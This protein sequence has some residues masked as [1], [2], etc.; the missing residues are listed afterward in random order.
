MQRKVFVSFRFNDGHLYK[1]KLCEVLSKS[2]NLIDCSEDKDRSKLSEPVIRDYLY[3]KLRQTSVTIILLTPDAIKHKKNIFGKID[4]WMYDEIRYSL[5]D[6]Q[7]NRTNGLVAVYTPEAEKLLITH[8]Y[9]NNA[10]S[11]AEVENLFRKN[12]MNIKNEYKHN[13]RYGMYDTDYDSYCSLISF[14]SFINNPE[15]YINIA[16]EKRDRTNEYEIKRRL[17]NN[18]YYF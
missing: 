1:E 16:E 13:Q 3:S 17:D 15:R 18:I 9:E 4:D 8:D 7:N 2:N 14:N 5:E 6:R 12:M 11:V 10:I